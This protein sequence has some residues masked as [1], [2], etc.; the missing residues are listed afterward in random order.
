MIVLTLELGSSPAQRGQFTVETVLAKPSELP[1]DVFDL[2]D[3]DRFRSQ[4]RIDVNAALKFLGQ[5]SEGNL[6]A[7][8]RLF[9]IFAWNAFLALNWAANSDGESRSIEELL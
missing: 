5:L 6:P 1:R 7:A 3:F 8:Q 9:D 4:G 2:P